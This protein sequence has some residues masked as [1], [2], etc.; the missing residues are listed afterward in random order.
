MIL[1]TALCSTAWNKIFDVRK[2]RNTHLKGHNTATKVAAA[3]EETVSEDK[4]T[5]FTV[6]RSF[7]T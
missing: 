3:K 4:I 2:L 6:Q 1:A 7:I 5:A